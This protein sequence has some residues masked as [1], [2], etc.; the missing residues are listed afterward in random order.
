M[1]A[2]M[3]KRMIGTILL[4]GIIF[5]QLSAHSGKPN[6]H[7]VI[8]TDGALDDMRSISMLLSQND[9]RVL[10]ITCSQG[11][12]LPDSVYVKVRSLLSAFH[13]E[14][15]PVGIGE[16]SDLELPEWSAFAQNITWGDAADDHNIDFREDATN[17]L[18]RTT[19]NYPHPLTLI[20][21]GSLKTYADWIS[22]NPDV[23]GK[24]ER[25]IWYNHHNIAKGFNYLVS[26]KSY[27]FIRQTGIQLDV[28]YNDSDRLIINENYFTGIRGATSVYARQ[29]GIVHAQPAIEERINQKHLQLWDDLVPVYLTV[30]ILFETETNEKIKYVSMYSSIPDTYVYETISQLLESA[31]VANNHVFVNFPVDPALY[32]PE[33]AKILNSTIENFGPV[34]WK[35]ISMTNEIHGHT[36]I[37][38]IIG[39]K[40]GIRAMEY[41]NVGVNNLI[42]ITFAGS[43]PPLSCFN[44]GVQISSGATIGQGLITVSDSISLIPSAIFEFNHQKVNISLNPEIARQMGND[45]RCGIEEHGLLTDAYWLFIEKL[46]IGY[47]T[48]FD[49]HDIFTVKKL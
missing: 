24:I 31:N 14:G 4:A 7:V 6:Y 42:V 27:E 2:H 15:I 1:S 20:A 35:A 25:I 18:V 36:G 13:H 19:E 11:T 30:P 22:E 29:I 9:I 45:I 37:Y 8:D 41:F 26:K 44:D 32:K 21:L 48:G 40:M 46:A 23:S 33:Y 49:R 39:A 28:V 5:S 43:E 34:E 3:I 38:S 47:W 12:L 10:A 16:K 17:L